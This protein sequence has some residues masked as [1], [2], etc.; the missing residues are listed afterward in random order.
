[1][2]P[3]RPDLFR[4][5]RYTLFPV[6][7]FFSVVF[8]LL[9]SFSHPFLDRHRRTS[10][11]LHGSGNR[12]SNRISALHLDRQTLLPFT[13]WITYPESQP[14][15]A[16]FISFSNLFLFFLMMTIFEFLFP[17]LQES[18]RNYISLVSTLIFSFTPTLW[19]QANSNEVYELNVLLAMLLLYLILSQI[20]L[21]SRRKISGQIK[22]FIFS[23]SF[24]G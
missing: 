21:K 14:A 6:I 3:A 15:I 7:L 22:S 5:N 24:T 9:D 11:S 4:F 13:F 8:Y 23:S 12:P 17:E 2:S 1:M 20:R 10:C 18:W 16:F 19:S